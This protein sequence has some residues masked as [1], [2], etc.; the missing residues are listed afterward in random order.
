M[1]D[2]AG[3]G[4]DAALISRYQALVCDLDGVVYQGK[5]PIDGAVDALGAVR[6][7]GVCVVYATNNASRPPGT[8]AAQ[9][10]SMG[11]GVQDRDVVNSSQA[12]A[13]LLR[14]VLGAG[15][16]VLAVGGP[17]VRIALTDAGMHPVSPAAAAAARGEPPVLAVLQGYGAEVGWSDLAEAA[18]AVQ[19]GARWVATNLDA[20]LPTE[21]G[22]AP[23][24]GS[25]VGAVRAAVDREP[26]VVGKPAPDVYQL[27]AHVA[28]VGSGD[29]L[30]VGDRIDT[31]IAGAH[32]A[33][34]DSLIVLTGVHG[35]GDL[36]ALGPQAPRPTFVARSLTALLAPYDSPVRSGEST[37]RCG[38]G[39]VELRH[40][41][42][43]PRL[44]TR[45]GGSGVLLLRAALTALWHL[46]DASQLT[47]EQAGE[48]M[49]EWVPTTDIDLAP[50]DAPAAK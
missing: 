50:Q 46:I 30:A 7:R 49:G 26:V 12:G 36:A 6:R 34:M 21:R 39:E 41:D 25:L 42:R 24:N 44:A 9:L 29:T 43:C 5:Q 22:L 35:P 16:R 18:F 28:G 47:T 8:V 27:A 48:I 15:A 38:S 2:Q 3:P 20:T 11:L 40:T 32:S 1:S 31:D 33:G 19:R 10:R 45:S 37:W 17:G 23:G 14:R 13:R 4:A